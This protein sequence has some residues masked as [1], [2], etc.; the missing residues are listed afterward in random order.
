MLRLCQVFVPEL[1][2]DA[3]RAMGEVLIQHFRRYMDRSAIGVV[4][5]I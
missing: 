4:E 2:E 1:Q 3:R 5:T